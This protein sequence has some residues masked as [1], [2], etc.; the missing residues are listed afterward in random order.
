MTE[1]PADGVMRI[2]YNKAQ[3]LPCPGPLLMSMPLTQNDTACYL[4]ENHI[5][6]YGLMQSAW[7][8]SDQ[9]EI[10]AKKVISCKRMG[11]GRRRHNVKA[12]TA[13]F[14][15]SLFSCLKLHFA[16]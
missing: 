1:A 6:N 15:L 3:G 4:R 9:E 16:V 5:F 2:D 14:S 10:E 12:F 11:Q 13:Q 7:N 8:T